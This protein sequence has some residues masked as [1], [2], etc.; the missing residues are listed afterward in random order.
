MDKHQKETLIASIHQEIATLGKDIPALQE[1]AKPVAPDNA[2]GRLT[3]MEAINSK[4]INEA[5]LASA[6]A[7]LARLEHA[8]KMSDDPD[9]GLCM[10]CGESI[11]FKRLMVLPDSGLCVSCAEKVSG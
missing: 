3:R 8:L 5:N 6:K 7:R 11:P 9:F 4:S 10:Q 1:L 2:I